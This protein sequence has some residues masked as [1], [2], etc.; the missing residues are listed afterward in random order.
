[1]PQFANDNSCCLW[2]PDHFLNYKEKLANF[3]YFWNFQTDN[4]KFAKPKVT[5]LCGNRMPPLFK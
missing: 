3:Q 5:I 1:M 2:A 4:T